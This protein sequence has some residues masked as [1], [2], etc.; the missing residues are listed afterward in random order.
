MNSFRL[1]VKSRELV[2]DATFCITLFICNW[3]N[4]TNDL[5]TL[6]IGLL[7]VT[8]FDTSSI[9]SNP[10]FIAGCAL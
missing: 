5:A 2:T 8:K 4:L 1:A 9:G 6:D 10:V 7:L 3:S